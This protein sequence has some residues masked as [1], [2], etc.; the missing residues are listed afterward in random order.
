M[1]VVEVSAQEYGN[2]FS[3]YVA[4]YNSPEFNELNREK[5]EEIKYLF[6]V[7]TKPRLGLIAGI[8]KGMLNSPFSAPFG[9]FTL[10][11]K[12]VG[13]QD[14]FLSI[15]ALEVYSRNLGL[16]DIRITLPPLFYQ[17]STIAKSANALYANGFQVSNIDLNFHFDLSRLN[18]RYPESLWRNARKN[19]RIALQQGMTF[20]E[21]TKEEDCTVAYEVIRCNRQAK[22]YPLRMTYEQVS[23]TGGVIA[24]HYFLVEFDRSTMAAAIVFEVAPRIVQ[25]IYWGDLPGNAQRKPVNF[26]S[27]RLFDHFKKRGFSVVDIGPS[28]HDS[29]PNFGLCD[30]KESIGCLT[31]LKLSF[32]KPLR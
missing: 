25:V 16:A 29:V 24:S 12:N 9:G 5:A 7:N 13:V 18:E 11:N 14:I 8:K 31:S 22:G 6:F 26:L 21:C 23:N 27:Y 32:S 3:D 20:R 17:E 2:R 15:Q 28:T 19:L 4:I 10:N 1:E 30:F